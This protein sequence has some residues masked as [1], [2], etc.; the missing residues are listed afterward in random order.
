MDARAKILETASRL[1]AD[2]GYD[3]TSL[4][5][6][7]RDASVS[8]ALILWHFETKEQLFREA[9]SHTIEPYAIRVDLDGRSEPEQLKHLVDLYYQFVTRN[10]RSVRFFLSLLL[11]D[12]ERPEDL[13][14]RVLELN[15]LYLA[16]IVDVLEKGQARGVIA[17]TVDARAH[18]QLVMSAL[19]GILVRG[20]V[21]PSRSD[22]AATVLANVKATLVDAIRVQ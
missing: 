13:V 8:K 15:D 5:Q 18:A 22:E 21:A 10:L 9:V 12:S 11:R 7:A 2:Q 4:S 1:F 3:S 14:G 19:N 6:V 17:R 20:F 16:Q